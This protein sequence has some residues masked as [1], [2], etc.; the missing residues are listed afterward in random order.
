MTIQ[1]YTYENNTDVHTHTHI[2]IYTLCVYIY[3][4]YMGIIVIV[5]LY[6]Y[7]RISHM[8]IHSHNSYILY[9][10]IYYGYIECRVTHRTS[11]ARYLLSSAVEAW[12]W[13]RSALVDAAPTEEHCLSGWSSGLRP[14]SSG[15]VGSFLAP[16]STRS[17]R[18]NVSKV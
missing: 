16:W 8:G 9:I 13:L 11:M 15:R 10:Y 12:R 6:I 17:L 18:G 4:Y 5:T 7:T 14:W 1:Y 3:I 2:Y